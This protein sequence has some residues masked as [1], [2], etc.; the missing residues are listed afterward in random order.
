MEPD[1]IC[2]ER[3]NPCCRPSIAFPS[4]NEALKDNN[5]FQWKILA[6]NMSSRNSLL[7]HT[8]EW[9]ER[10]EV[11]LNAITARGAITLAIVNLEDYGWLSDSLLDDSN[12]L[13]AIWGN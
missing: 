2:K 13:T 8:E 3:R 5:L 7:N 4:I 12:L 1:H 10:V 11:R 6:S 9:V